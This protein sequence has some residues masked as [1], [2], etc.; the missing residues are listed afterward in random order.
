[1]ALNDRQKRFVIEYCV[2]FNG[3]QAAIRS[4]YA[5]NSA[6]DSAFNLLSNSEI[7]AAIEERQREVA[8]AASLT[9]QWV[10]DQWRQ[11]ASADP[12]DLIYTEL[13]CCRHCYGL[14]HEYQW[15]QF[16]F[17]KVVEESMN[18][19][20]GEKCGAPCAKKVPPLALG[21]F[22][23]TPHKSPNPDCPRC[24][25]NGQL[26][27]CVADS[28]SVKGPARR[29]YAGVKQT[30]HGIEVKMRDQ[31]AAL[32]NIAKYLGMLI[33]KRELAGP[34]GQP[35]PIAQFSAKDLTDDQLAQVLLQDA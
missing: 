9:V 7:V 12:N 20:C 1:M 11:I 14:N 27:V 18:H 26:R 3:T 5:P 2:D 34:N 24:H 28:R 35:I 10:L 15:T 19:R 22:G 33:D 6:H 30:Q 25:G 17:G 8:A 32:S 31:D 21:G 4:S 13:E 29:L 16:E 23:F